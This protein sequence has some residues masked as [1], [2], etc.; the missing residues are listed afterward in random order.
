SYGGYVFPLPSNVEFLASA[1]LRVVKWI[2]SVGSPDESPLR[3]SGLAGDLRA[4][5]LEDPASAAP[6]LSAPVYVSGNASSWGFGPTEFDVTAITTR[7]LDAGDER[8]VYRL[9]LDS[10]PDDLYYT[11]G[12][13]AAALTLVYWAL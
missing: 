11:G 1:S 4:P 9:G 2:G 6:I 8:S 12:C 10:A 7:G 3:R 5:A 13:A